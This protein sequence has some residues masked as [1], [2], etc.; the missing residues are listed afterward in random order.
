[1]QNVLVNEKALESTESHVT[2]N[3]PPYNASATTPQE[4]YVLDQIILKGEWDHL[5]D[6]YNILQQGEAVNFSSYPSFI[7]N[8]ME[9]LK[10]I[11]VFIYVYSLFGQLLIIGDYL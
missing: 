4:A 3:I 9:K 2:R 8:R 10:K 6:I 5:E 7:R 1:M 11:E